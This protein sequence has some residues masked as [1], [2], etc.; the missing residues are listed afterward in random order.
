MRCR[1]S[2]QGFGL[3]WTRRG[4]AL[5]LRPWYRVCSQS[6]SDQIFVLH[7]GRRVAIRV[8]D[9]AGLPKDFRPLHG[10]RHS[11]A[12]R[13][14]SSGEVDMYRLQTLMT[15]KEPKMTQRYAHLAD[16]A[17]K[18]AADVAAK[19]MSKPDNKEG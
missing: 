3:F 6:E 19:V 1:L 10:L 11:F 13:I 5:R 2:Q 16:E 14:A 12:S 7:R 17:M 18:K 4:K 9:K 8:R 15:H